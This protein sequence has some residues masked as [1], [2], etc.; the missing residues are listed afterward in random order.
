LS[1]RD[2]PG[3]EGAAQHGKTEM[4]LLPPIRIL[5]TIQRGRLLQSET[6]AIQEKIKTLI[7]DDP[8]FC[9]VLAKVA[10]P[11]SDDAQYSI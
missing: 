10:K 2:N 1:R 4:T 11:N 6:P 7:P 3:E 9:P 8:Y 5:N